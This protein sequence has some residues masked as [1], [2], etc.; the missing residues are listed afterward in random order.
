[1][2]LCEIDRNWSAM[3]V[4]PRLLLF[5]RQASWLL[6]EW[7]F[8]NRLEVSVGNAPTKGGFADRSVHLLGQRPSGLTNGIRTRTAAFTGRDAALT[9]W[10]TLEMVLPRGLAPRTSAFAKRRAGD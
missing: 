4:L 7:H 5:G 10:S 3:P 2:T 8:D 9:S 6:D 1:M